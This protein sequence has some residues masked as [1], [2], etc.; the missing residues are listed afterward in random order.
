MMHARGRESPL[1][2]NKSPTVWL[3]AV[4]VCPLRRRAASG[5]V[6][7]VKGDAQAEDTDCQLC[8]TIGMCSTIEMAQGCLIS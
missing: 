1:V 3:M 8:T 7:S 2:T 6:R 5:V 4:L